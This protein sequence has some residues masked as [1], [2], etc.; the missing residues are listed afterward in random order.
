[1]VNDF[2]LD[3]WYY[4][5][6]IDDPI[7][8]NPHT[9]ELQSVDETSVETLIS[10]GFQEEV[11]KKALKASVTFFSNSINLKFCMLSLI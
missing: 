8:Q 7:S 4:N 6:D 5:A 3:F 10:F 11:A 2:Q 9:M 1:M